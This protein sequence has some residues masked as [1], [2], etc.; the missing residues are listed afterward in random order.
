MEQ[1]QRL[2]YDGL[3]ETAQATIAALQAD[4]RTYIDERHEHMKQIEQLQARVQELIVEI[5]AIRKVES[6]AELSEAAHRETVKECTKEEA[7]EFVYFYMNKLTQRTAELHQ[8]LAAID[9]GLSLNDIGLAVRTVEGVQAEL[10]AVCKWKIELCNL[11]PGGSEFADDPAYCAEWVRKVRENQ[12]DII[13]NKCREAKSLKA[14]LE[15]VKGEW[16]EAN[17]LVA[18]LSSKVAQY[19]VELNG[20]PQNFYGRGRTVGLRALIAALPKVEGEILEQGDFA[21]VRYAHA[22]EPLPEIPRCNQIALLQ[23]RKRMEE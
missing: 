10:E 17:E 9:E 18:A 15:R 11:T 12:H 20:D 16:D 4:N 13:L 22:D 7:I 6:Q 19:E 14:E 3:F 21:F 1:E 23:H 8:V 2:D 5:A